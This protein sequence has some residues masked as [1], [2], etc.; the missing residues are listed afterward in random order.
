MNVKSLIKNIVNQFK[1][2]TGIDYNAEK[3]WKNRHKKY[4]LDMRGVGNNGLTLEKNIEQY[5][6]AKNIFIGL[7]K[8]QHIKFKDTKVLD[9]GCGIG[10]YSNIFL[11]NGTTDYTGIDITE[12]MFKELKNKYSHYLF[13]KLDITKDLCNGKYD[14]ILMIDVTQ[15]IIAID[16]FSFAMQNIRTCLSDSGIFIVTSWLDPNIRK[17]FYEVSRPIEIY[18]AAFPGYKFSDPI[19]F[20]DKYIF[21]I[22]K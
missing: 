4:G 18:K 20:R 16:K 10:Y 8:S 7:C 5:E 6:E 14:L 3:Y 12:V 21:T 17:E 22:K 13:K 1:Y 19:P 11:E 15:H 2:S 9:I